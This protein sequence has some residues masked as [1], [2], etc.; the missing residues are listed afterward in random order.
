MRPEIKQDEKQEDL[1]VYKYEYLYP[2]K[3]EITHCVKYSILTPEEFLIC[4]TLA[5]RVF[6]LH[7]TKIKLKEFKA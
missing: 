6:N 5:H 1:Y 3:G 4:E 7:F 2:C